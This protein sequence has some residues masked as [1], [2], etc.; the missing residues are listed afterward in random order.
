MPTVAFL[1]LVLLLVN[2]LGIKKKK[3]LPFEGRAFL[4]LLVKLFGLDRFARANACAGAAVDAL[5]RI[6]YINITGRDC[7]YR[8]FVDTCAASYAQIGTNFV[9]HFFV[10]FKL[11]VDGANIKIYLIISKPV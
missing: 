2:V 9:S 11:C 10:L 1:N 4:C 6:D 7:L 8:T 3:A 5:V